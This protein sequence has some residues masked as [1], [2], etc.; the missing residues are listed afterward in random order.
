MKDLTIEQAAANLESL[1]NQTALK[2]ADYDVLY[3]S[4]A[5]LFSTAKQTQE[6]LKESEK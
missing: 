3:N 5:L 2:K 6:V 1:L 4:L